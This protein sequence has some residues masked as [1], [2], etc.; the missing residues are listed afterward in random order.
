M[1][2]LFSYNQEKYR[3]G[4]RDPWA[5]KISHPRIPL[6]QYR[7]I[8]PLPRDDFSDEE[9]T[10]SSDDSDSDSDDKPIIFPMRR[11]KPP[12]PVPKR[13]IPRI[14]KKKIFRPIPKSVP[15][16]QNKKRADAPPPREPPPPT[17]PPR[18]SRRV[19]KRG[20]L[21]PSHIPHK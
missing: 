21:L 16:E 11:K 3:S 18:S 2:H 15:R 14:P 9:S 1:V 7:G 6:S 8:E 4:G 19:Q 5:A 17:R 12:P 10:D 13:N 20:H